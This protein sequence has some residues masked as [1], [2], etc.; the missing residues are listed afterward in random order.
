[1]SSSSTPQPEQPAKRSMDEAATIAR[2]ALASG[3]TGKDKDKS[4]G[5]VQ[6]ARFVVNDE[7]TARTMD[8]AKMQQEVHTASSERMRTLVLTPAMIAQRLGDE[9]VRTHLVAQL[10]APAPASYA[11]LRETVA[12]FRAMHHCME[13]PRDKDYVAK[14]AKTLGVD[15]ERLAASVNSLLLIEKQKPEERPAGYEPVA[16]ALKRAANRL[17]AVD[18]G[19]VAYR[20]AVAA[21]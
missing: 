20:E 15:R 21:L 17:D 7:A 1:M 18:R 11:A 16:S 3:E 19:V 13:H 14:A 2:D 8:A 9:A 5:A 10:P 6:V 4:A 12:L